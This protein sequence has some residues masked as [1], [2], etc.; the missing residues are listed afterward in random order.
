[1]ASPNSTTVKQID[2]ELVIEP[3][4]QGSTFKI[5]LASHKG[6]QVPLRL[7]GVWTS[8]REAKRAI[9]SWRQSLINSVGSEG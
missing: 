6:A 2:D 9:E 1:M 7:D 3:V 5:K 4:P 8:T